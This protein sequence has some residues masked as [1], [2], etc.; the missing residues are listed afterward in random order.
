MQKLK[1]FQSIEFA[2][3]L[4]FRLNRIVMT[5]TNRL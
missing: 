5:F 4:S 1:D 2:T 3:S